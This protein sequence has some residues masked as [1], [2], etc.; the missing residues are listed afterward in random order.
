LE[1]IHQL[2]NFNFV[3]KEIIFF[4]NKVLDFYNAQ[5]A[6]VQTKIEYVLDLVR[7]EKHVPIKFY[8][9][10]ENTN[11]I[12][13]V[14]VITS[15]KSIRILCFQEQERIIVL[16]NAFVKKSQKTPKGEIQQA[17]K[18]KVEYLAKKEDEKNQNI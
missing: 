10:L 3:E 7:F 15:Q 2:V 14:R 4:G 18:L 11:G 5:N 6:K 9:K 16:T 12:Y 8:K 17:I 13:E 1:N